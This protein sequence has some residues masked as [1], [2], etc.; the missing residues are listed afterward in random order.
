M[1]S[2]LL[3]EKAFSLHNFEVSAFAPYLNNI[4][5][6]SAAM[7]CTEQYEG[8]FSSLS[9]ASNLRPAPPVFSYSHHHLERLY[10]EPFERFR[11]P[12]G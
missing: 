5:I 6:K 2:R 8:L 4:R 1:A 11:I 3:R 12:R 10:E 7:L 9:Q